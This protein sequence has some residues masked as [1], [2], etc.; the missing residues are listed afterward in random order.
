M[1]NLSSNAI[2]F[3]SSVIYPRLSQHLISKY[4]NVCCASVFILVI[5]M[6][7]SN[8]K[9]RLNWNRKLK[10]KMRSEMALN[11]ASTLSK[12]CLILAKEVCILT[13][14]SYYY[15]EYFIFFEYTS[16]GNLLSKSLNIPHQTIN[17]WRHIIR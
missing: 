13:H 5:F 14:Y 6:R 7:I 9:N 17:F 11:F 3:F 15:F 8:I 2:S 4:L 12:M 1:T 10:V 16:F